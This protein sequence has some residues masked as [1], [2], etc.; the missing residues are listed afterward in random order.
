MLKLPLRGQLLLQTYVNIFLQTYVIIWFFSFKIM[1]P[2]KCRS[3]RLE[4]RFVR[5]LHTLLASDIVT[6]TEILCAVHE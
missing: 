5:L 3:D 2:I 4:Q 6:D 1:A